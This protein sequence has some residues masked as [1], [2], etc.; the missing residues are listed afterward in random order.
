MGQRRQAAR[1]IGAPRL[2]FALSAAV[3]LKPREPLCHILAFAQ[4]VDQDLRDSRDG[5]ILQPADA[6]L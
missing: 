1:F 4:A 2:A 3:Q 5:R 6:K